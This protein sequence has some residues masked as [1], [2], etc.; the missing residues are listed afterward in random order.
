MPTL[1][2]ASLPEI[3]SLGFSV[4]RSSF[5]PSLALGPSTWRCLYGCE[6]R[7]SRIKFVLGNME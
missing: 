1:A 4:P 5:H 7:S 2:S 3:R 6:L